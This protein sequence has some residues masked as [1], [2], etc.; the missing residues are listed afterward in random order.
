MSVFKIWSGQKVKEM[1]KKFAWFS[2]HSSIPSFSI[3]KWI[4]NSFLIDILKYIFYFF[5][6]KNIKKYIFNIFNKKYIFKKYLKIVS[7][8]ITN[9]L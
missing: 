7:N 8:E 6:I 5:K 4:L 3:V 1:K 2:L 9:I